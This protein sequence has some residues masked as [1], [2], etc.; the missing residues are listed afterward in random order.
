MAALIPA[1]REEQNIHQVV[2]ESAHHVDEVWVIDDGSDDRTAQLAEAAGACVI[3]HEVNRGKGAAIKTG[4]RAL[5]ERGVLYVVALD[6]D[7]QHLPGEIPRFI[8][9]AD[10]CEAGLIIGNR[11][12]DVRGM[13]LVRRLVNRYMS[14]RISA[15]AGTFIPDTQ[16]GFR[17]LRRDVIPSLVG[18]SDHFDFE[19]EMIFRAAET[20]CGI[21]SMPVTTIYGDEQSKIHPWHDTVRFLRLMKKWERRLSCRT[22]VPGRAPCLPG[23]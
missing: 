8:A 7:G 4:L 22:S 21:D 23:G 2:S 17:L 19:T 18:E 14:R 5:L 12:G 15:I 10:E 13:P 11:F 16:C 1:L 6:G 20:G 3:R 9:R